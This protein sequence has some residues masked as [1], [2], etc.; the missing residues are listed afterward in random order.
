MA[1]SNSDRGVGVRVPPLSF[2]SRVLRLSL[3]VSRACF[4]GLSDHRDTLRGAVQSCHHVGPLDA[5]QRRTQQ[6]QC[7][8]FFLGPVREER[9]SGGLSTPKQV[10]LFGLVAQ[11]CAQ[12]PPPPAPSFLQ[13][14][15]HLFLSVGGQVDV[16]AVVLPAVPLGTLQETRTKLAHRLA[17]STEKINTGYFQ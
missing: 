8:A 4:Q 16:Q 1:A 6:S 14:A 3:L 10:Q 5:S 17:V 7:G 12:L 15:L 9:V 2:K 11:R 13:E